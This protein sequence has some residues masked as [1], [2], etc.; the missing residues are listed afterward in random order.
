MKKVLSLVGGMVFLFAVGMVYAAED[1]SMPSKDSSDK[2]YGNEDMMR[3]NTDQS[4]NP[5][6]QMPSEPGIQGS[7]AGGPSEG[8]DTM[9]NDMTKDKA[10]A[11]KKIDKEKSTEGT[12][13]GDTYK[14]YMRNG[15]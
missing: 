10:P 3:Y 6:N 4:E 12:G 13:G 5:V 9:T 11:E 1:T 14:D 7:G 8:S 15:Y 2:T